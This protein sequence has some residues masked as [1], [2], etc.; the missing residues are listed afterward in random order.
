MLRL[1]F[2]RS[3]AIAVVL[4]CQQANPQTAKKSVHAKRK[5]GEE[6]QKQHNTSRIKP[7]RHMLLHQV[8]CKFKHGYSFH[9]YLLS[10]YPTPL[11]PATPCR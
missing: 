1:I 11:I 6:C 8:E 9:D 7:G 10:Y 4:P 3:F 5:R 2:F